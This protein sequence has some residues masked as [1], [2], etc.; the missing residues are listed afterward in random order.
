RRRLGEILMDA[1]VLDEMQL[2]AALSEQRKWG[3]KLGRTLVEMGFVD[4]DS[5]TLALS[6]QLNLPVGNLDGQG[7]PAEVV[8]STRVDSAARP[9]P[10][11]GRRTLGCPSDA[12][13]PS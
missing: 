12:S 6:R 3:G 7:P 11:P 1:G 4:E 10:T 13:R 8:Q 9:R 2:K 5:M